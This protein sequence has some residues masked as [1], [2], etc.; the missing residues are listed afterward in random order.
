MWYLS[1]WEGRIIIQNS[2]L[3]EVE[4]NT[5]LRHRLLRVTKKINY[6]MAVKKETCQKSLAARQSWDEYRKI[7][8]TTDDR[9]YLKPSTVHIYIERGYIRK[10]GIQ[11]GEV[12]VDLASR[13]LRYSFEFLMTKIS[14]RPIKW[15]YQNND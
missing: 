8:H 14:L 10:A 5:M 4:V 2:R 13:T 12:T 7:F 1:V 15:K 9:D 11:F 6:V 3:N